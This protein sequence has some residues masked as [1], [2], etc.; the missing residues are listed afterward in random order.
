MQETDKK[1]RFFQIALKLIAESGFKA[2]TMRSLAMTM[3]CDVSN[4]YNYVKSK[5]AL[6]EHLLFEISN[7]FHQ[8]MIAIESS[9]ENP[10]EK[11]KA[12]IALHIGLTVENPYQVVLLVNE[13]RHLKAEKQHDFILLRDTYEKKLQVILAEGA[14]IGVFKIDNLD[15][16]SNCILSSIRW[17]YDWYNPI[18]PSITPMELERLM[19][20][21]IFNGIDK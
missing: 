3:N 2:M 11:L 1:K 6:L 8:G 15:F 10:T 5:H 20:K 17:L 21:F 16:T 18:H 12:V 13:W 14:E 19:T 9:N 4:I 7:K